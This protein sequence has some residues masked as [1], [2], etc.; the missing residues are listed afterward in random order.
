MVC[1]LMTGQAKPYKVEIGPFHSISF[2][3]FHKENLCLMHPHCGPQATYGNDT[4][5]SFTVF[6]QIHEILGTV[7]LS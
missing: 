3:S 5:H 7:V 4:P 2:V 6:L 1:S